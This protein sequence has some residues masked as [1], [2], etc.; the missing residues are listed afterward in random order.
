MTT[1]PNK[2][3]DSVSG[4]SESVQALRGM[5]YFTRG[6]QVYS[7]WLA[8]HVRPYPVRNRNNAKLLLSDYNRIATPEAIIPLAILWKESIYVTEADLAEVRIGRASRFKGL[9]A[10]DLAE[11]MQAADCLKPNPRSFGKYIQRAR[12]IV[13]G[14]Q[15]YGLVQE[16]DENSGKYRENHKPL[17]GTELLHTLMTIVGPYFMVSGSSTEFIPDKKYLSSF[18]KK[19]R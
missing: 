10:T 5:L 9:T 19:E 11:A 18:E 12:R 13:I 17:Q 2:P 3:G 1:Y 16:H 7:A 4:Q 6:V 8:E 14:A 15:T